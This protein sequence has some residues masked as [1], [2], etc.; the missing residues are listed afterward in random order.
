MAE[1]R[2]GVAPHIELALCSRSSI[3]ALMAS[4]SRRRTVLVILTPQWATPPR[5]GFDTG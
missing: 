1:E 3:V 2:T 5:M 4:R